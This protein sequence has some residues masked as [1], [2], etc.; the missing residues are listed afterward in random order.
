MPIQ[1][2]GRKCALR[3][4]FRR[5]MLFTAAP[6]PVIFL[7][8]LAETMHW[9][10]YHTPFGDAMMLIVAGPEMLAAIALERYVPVSRGWPEGLKATLQLAVFMMR[11]GVVFGYG[12]FRLSRGKHAPYAEILWLLVVCAFVAAWMWS[13]PS[14]HRAWRYGY[15]A[16]AALAGAVVFALQR[17]RPPAWNW[18]TPE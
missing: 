15:A 12:A 2:R 10:P 1:L 14:D 6:V 4:A 3:G 16:A 8:A 18:K 5:W 17:R 7:F 9:I 11:L 13:P